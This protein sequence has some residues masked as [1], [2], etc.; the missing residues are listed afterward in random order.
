[1]KRVK[2]RFEG[3]LSKKKTSDLL[4]EEISSD[5][6]PDISLS[7]SFNE[8]TSLDTSFEVFGPIFGELLNLPDSFFVI[9]FSA[10]NKLDLVC[11][12]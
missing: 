3:A 9:L 8:R 10:L 6:C 4:F 5:I 12:N 2:N 1:M 11:H 7:S